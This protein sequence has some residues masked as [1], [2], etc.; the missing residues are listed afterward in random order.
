MPGDEL[1]E[2]VMRLLKAYRKRAA[3]LDVAVPGG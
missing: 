2:L 3:E 1:R